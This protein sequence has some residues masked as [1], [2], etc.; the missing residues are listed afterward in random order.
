MREEPINDLTE[1]LKP[2]QHE[3]LIAI[4]FK[5]A[6]GSFVQALYWTWDNVDDR[7][8]K[9]DQLSMFEAA[10]MIEDMAG[11]LREHALGLPPGALDFLAK[12]LSQL[13]KEEDKK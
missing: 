1:V 12:A 9:E 11:L 3:P 13:L 5:T 2:G 7:P 10:E 6:W 4:S 8:P